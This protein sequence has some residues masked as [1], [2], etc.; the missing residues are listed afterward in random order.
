MMLVK[1]IA[2]LTTQTA[3]ATAARAT[4]KLQVAVAS[5]LGL[6]RPGYGFCNQNMIIG[7]A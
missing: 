4:Q 6:H 7:L 1:K 2:I 3:I 5:S